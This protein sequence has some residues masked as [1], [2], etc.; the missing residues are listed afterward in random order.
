L[1]GALPAALDLRLRFHHRFEL[2]AAC[3]AAVFAVAAGEFVG[4]LN[5]HPA[6][7]SDGLALKRSLVAAL[8]SVDVVVVAAL[9]ELAVEQVGDAP[10][11]DLR[12]VPQRISRFL[13]AA[14]LGDRHAH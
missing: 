12:I 6:G 2:A 11:G 13:S 9:R 14:D 3:E 7:C 4:A 8:V 10:V 1:V 5:G